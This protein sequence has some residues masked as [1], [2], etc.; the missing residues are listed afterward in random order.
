MMIVMTKLMNENVES[1]DNA[2]DGQMI[3]KIRIT[4]IRVTTRNMMTSLNMRLLRRNDCDRKRD[5]VRDT[6]GSRVQA[7]RLGFPPPSC[8]KSLGSRAQG[9]F[10][11]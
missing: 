9:S 5:N 4:A 7:V 3:R 1:D 2:H 8:L 10:R 11:A 6:L